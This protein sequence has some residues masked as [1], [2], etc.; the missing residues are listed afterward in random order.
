[1]YQLSV[2]DGGRCDEVVD[3]KRDRET[4]VCVDPVSASSQTP[5]PRRPE[6]VNGRQWGQQPSPSRQNTYP[7]GRV[8]DQDL[9]GLAVCESR[10]M[11]EH[12]TFRET[13]NGQ[14][15]DDSGAGEV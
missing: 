1:M 5:K 7:E 3:V 6:D 11:E 14:H 12:Q 8:V 13:I 4:V 2:S 15:T 10:M 9:S